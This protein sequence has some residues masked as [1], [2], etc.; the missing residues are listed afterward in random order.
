[1]LWFSIP[2]V[3][4]LASIPVLIVVSQLEE[5]NMRKYF[6]WEN[7]VEIYCWFWACNAAVTLQYLF[8]LIFGAITVGACYLVSYINGEL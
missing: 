3:I 5:I 2:L 8:V 7:F 4:F 1:M 6:K